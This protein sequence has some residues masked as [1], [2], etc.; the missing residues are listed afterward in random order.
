[1]SA[2]TKYRQTMTE[3]VNQMHD[4]IIVI[5]EDI[6]YIK[7][8]LD[9]DGKNCGL[10]ERVQSHETFI[11]SLRAQISLGAWILG[12]G[13]LFSAIAIVLTLWQIFK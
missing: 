13:V 1:M 11:D 2:T 8:C 3:T 6:K 12:G 10:I 5:K 7:K 9:G 4:D